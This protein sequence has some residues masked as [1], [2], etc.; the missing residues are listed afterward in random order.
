[1]GNLGW[2]GYLLFMVC[3]FAFAIIVY[4]FYPE[5]TGRRLEEID[6]IFY[7]TSPIVCGT[8]WTKKGHFETEDIDRAILNAGVGKVGAGEYM[9]QAEH[10]DYVDG[11]GQVQV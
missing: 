9:G 2:K 8:K 11:K 3:N 7:R 4:V 5:T 6:A 1:M 10:Q